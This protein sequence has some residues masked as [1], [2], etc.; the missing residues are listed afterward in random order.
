MSLWPRHER[1]SRG[2][3][4]DIDDSDRYDER[5]DPVSAGIIKSLAQPGG[6]ITGISTLS[7]EL[8]TKRL[9]VIKDVVPKLTLLGV[10]TVGELEM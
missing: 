4:S 8:I 2:K 10:L 9:E 7:P 1:G 3:A 5:G 6:N